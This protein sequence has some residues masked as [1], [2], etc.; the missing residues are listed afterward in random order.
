MTH[1]DVVGLQVAG[2]MNG[3]DDV[4]FLQV[5]GFMNRADNMQGIQASGFVN[6]II[7]FGSRS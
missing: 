6:F 2:F 7:A 4:K 3:A 5:A 1:G